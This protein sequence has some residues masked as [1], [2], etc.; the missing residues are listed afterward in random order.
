MPSSVALVLMVLA[1]L[2]MPPDPPGVRVVEVTTHPDT[3]RTGDTLRVRVALRVAQGLSITVPDTLAS[4]PGL[5]GRGSVERTGAAVLEYPLQALQ[6]GSIPLPPLKLKVSSRREGPGSREERW[7]SLPLGRLQV[8]SVLPP[9][10][11]EVS[12]A[13][14]RL[15]PP[16]PEPGPPWSLPLSL[17]GLA[18]SGIMWR[19]ARREGDGVPEGV[20]PSESRVPG[21]GPGTESTTLDELLSRRP[22]TPTEARELLARVLPRIRREAALTVGLETPGLTTPELLEALDGRAGARG[23]RDGAAV[24]ESG[25]KRPDLRSSLTLLVEVLRDGEDACF[26]KELPSPAWVQRW[27]DRVRRLREASRA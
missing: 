11:P 7:V 10:P 3:V 23:P 25:A 19:R 8:V 9:P 18:L 5:V 16:V 1:L 17:V 14:P 12:P 2:Q 4:F 6:S 22:R 21:Q 27:L 15:P 13:P 24:P 20:F 26:R